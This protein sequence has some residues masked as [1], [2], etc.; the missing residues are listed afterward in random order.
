MSQSD[1][2]GSIGVSL[3]LIGF[4]LNLRGVLT[5]NSKIYVT[6]NIIGA[7]LCGYSAYLIKFYPFVILEGVWA[8]AAFSSLFKR[9]PRG[10]LHS[11]IINE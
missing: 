9:V 6:L 2:L 11:E 4:L 1:I 5:S 3:L 10:T 8:I 7:I